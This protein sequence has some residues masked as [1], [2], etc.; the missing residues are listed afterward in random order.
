MH[1]AHSLAPGNGLETIHSARVA[2]LEQPIPERVQRWP[3]KSPKWHPE[4]KDKNQTK[5]L[6]SGYQ[7]GDFEGHRCTLVYN[8][9]AVSSE[10]KIKLKESF[11]VRFQVSESMW[12]VYE[13]PMNIFGKNGF[14]FFLIF[15]LDFRT[16]DFQVP[17]GTCWSE[18]K[19]LGKLAWRN[20]SEGSLRSQMIQRV[21]IIVGTRF[22]NDKVTKKHHWD[23]LGAPWRLLS[24]KNFF[25]LMYIYTRK[26][27]PP[28]DLDWISPTARENVNCSIN[29]WISITVW[30]K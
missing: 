10:P 27:R 2:V 22:Y 25:P 26:V 17:G 9:V 24:K 18:V 7:L 20:L 15:Q 12:N 29:S 13:G 28:S 5:S 16:W 3:L 30:N 11:P 14:S 6:F 4:N 23:T 19:I 8:H 21:E 1:S